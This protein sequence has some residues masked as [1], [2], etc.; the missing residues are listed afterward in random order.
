MSNNPF[1]IHNVS[2]AASPLAP[3]RIYNAEEFIGP[4][5]KEAEN[6]GIASKWDEGNAASVVVSNAVLESALKRCLDPHIK[7]V[8]AL[9]Q[10]LADAVADLKTGQ[11]SMVQ[12]AQATKGLANEVRK[13]VQDDRLQSAITAS[14]SSSLSAM[15]EQ[16]LSR[17]LQNQT[18]Y[19]TERVLKPAYVALGDELTARLA[20]NLENAEES[21][22]YHITQTAA[23]PSTPSP[24]MNELRALLSA[25]VAENGVLDQIRGTLVSLES[26]LSGL[27]QMTVPAPQAS[28]GLESRSVG[29]QMVSPHEAG[30]EET[31]LV[32]I[33]DIVR[34]TYGIPK[35]ERWTSLKARNAE[36]RCFTLKTVLSA[37]NINVPTQTLKGRMAISRQC[38]ADFVRW[39]TGNFPTMVAGSGDRGKTFSCRT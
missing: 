35:S 30:E 6:R 22:R 19:L 11:T 28:T 29:E 4:I 2:H 12:C 15:L 9:H 20:Q 38:R 36:G 39:M 14:L 37:D 3:L 7:V 34:S 33:A 23:T 26:R 5:R 25:V 32:A 31:D 17:S 24:D 27:E 1:P 21:L 8:Q 16:H 18:V 10:K 13:F